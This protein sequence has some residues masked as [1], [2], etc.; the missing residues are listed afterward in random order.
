MAQTREAVA[1]IKGYYYQF[2]FFILKLLEEENRDSVI[3]IEGIEDV[4]IENIDEKSAI[5]CKYYETTEYQHSKIKDA[6]I[7]MF[8]HYVEN[9][10][11]NLKYCLY[12]HYKSGQE[13]L[14]Q[15]IDIKFLKEKFLTYNKNSI[16]HRVYL[17]QNVDDEELQR[18]LQVLNI[19]ID[20]LNYEEQQ[21]KIIKNI[22]N[23][24]NCDEC[25]AESYYSTALLLIKEMSTQTDI[26]K[27]KITPNKFLNKIKEN[28]NNLF[29][30]LFIIKNGEDKYCKL[31]KKI[32][33]SDRN[34][35]P[36]SRFFLIEID[37]IITN[38]EIKNLI[39]IIKDKWGFV[40][41]RNDKSYCPYILLYNID[42]NRIIEIKKT[43]QA[44]SH[45]FVDGYDFKNAEFNPKSIIKK[46]TN[47]NGIE[48]KFVN[49]INELRKTIENISTTKE[50][51]Q[52]YIENIF[53]EN[54]ENKHEKI[55][56]LKTE[57]VINMI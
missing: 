20:A 33:F 47:Y 40:S 55:K 25:I 41:K 3:C 10:A 29:N 13:K 24:F 17:E 4:D 28:N 5:Q 16:T 43:I 42:E 49:D 26:R 27:R 15:I 34:V 23:I 14:P 46:P 48:F 7:A 35:S 36:Y 44:E 52:F 37:S 30:S 32:H 18:F 19:N 8:R 38:T 31:I 54:T 6:I 51:Y 1:T 50:I 2:D 45:I 39:Y 11:L 56:I 21:K 22:K 57:N 12:G 9:K 53:F